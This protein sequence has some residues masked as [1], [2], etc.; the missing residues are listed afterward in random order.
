M[1]K[2]RLFFTLS[3]MSFAVSAADD[4]VLPAVNA[5]KELRIAAAEDRGLIKFAVA[6]PVKD[7]KMQNGQVQHGSWRKLGNGK[8]QWKLRFSAKNA[9]GLDIGMSDFF[10]PHSAQLTVSSDDGSLQL[11][12]YTDRDNPKDGFFWVG[13]LAADHVNMV[14]TVSEAEKDF[15][16]F[17]IDNVPRSF[18]QPWLKEAGQQQNKSG[19]CNVDVACI[20]DSSW[21]SEVDSVGQYS[22]QTVTGGYVCTGQLINNTAQDGRPYF[23]T[24]DHCGYSGD[25]GQQPLSVRQ[26]VAASISI[27]WNYQSLTC[28]PPGSAQSGTVISPS[29]FTQRQRG[30]RYVASNPVSDMALVMLNQ[31]PPSSWGVKYTGW[32]RTNT[33]PQN[34]AVSIHHPNGDAKR[35]SR[36]N[37]PLTVTSYGSTGRGDAS[38][39]RVADWNVGTTER[40]SSG[41][42]LWNA[43]RLLIGQ[44]HGGEAACGNSKPDWY[45]RFYTSWNN[46]T[47]SQSRLK[48]WLDPINSGVM[49]LQKFGGCSAPQLSLSADG[50][51]AVG[52]D[53]NFA[54]VASGGSGTYRYAWDINGDGKTDS[55]QANFTASFSHAFDGNINLTVTDSS[56]CQSKAS[57]ALIVKAPAVRLQRQ[58][59]L[60]QICGNNDA[61]IDPGERWAS[62]LTF[63]NTS[64]TVGTDAYAVFAVNRLADQTGNSDRFGNSVSSCKS[65]FIDISHTG[66]QR[67]W[68]ATTTNYAAHDEGATDPIP[69]TQP[70][71]LYGETIFSLR[72]STNG[73]LSP[74]NIGGYDYTNDCPMPAV[75]S[76]DGGSSRIAVLHDDLANSSFYHQH[77]TVCPR[78]A[79]TGSN[80]PCDV[81]MWKGADLYDT[82]D[83]VER[84]DFQAILYPSTSQWAFQYGDSINGGSSSTGI[85]NSNASDGVSYACNQAGSISSAQAVC[86][87]HKDNQPEAAEVIID[88]PTIALGNLNGSTTVD[89]EFS[90]PKDSDCGSVFS[91]N[92]QATVF[93]EGFNPG[94]NGII[95]GTIG[96]NGSCQVV[97]HCQ[98]DSSHSIDPTD[99][100]WW[101]PKRS[102]NG[103]NFFFVRDSLVYATYTGKADGSPVWYIT[104][105]TSNAAR[106]Q[107]FNDLQHISYNGGFTAGGEQTKTTVGWS[108]TIVLDTTNLIQVREINGKISAEKMQLQIFDNA[109]AVNQY[110]GWWHADSE[111]GWGENVAIQGSIRFLL[112]YLYDQSGQPYWVLGTG[113]NDNSPIDLIYVKTFCPSCPRVDPIHTPAGSSHLQLNEQGQGKIIN[114]DIAVPPEWRA[115][116]VW[117]RQNVPLV[118][119]SFGL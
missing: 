58:G 84:A 94:Q 36:E 64:S 31:V 1:N 62:R 35:I 16:R 29:T 75:P 56:G 82:G 114:I 10:L 65:H 27:I 111:S 28:R 115:G 42:G 117:Q 92:H 70:F 95:S 41:A 46:G 4:Y 109:P 119:L 17:N 19:S 106:N 61:N 60:Q 72:A 108:N 103:T 101:N 85:Q 67:Q 6:T 18:A 3:V 22:F 37:D 86:V 48:D 83:V 11:G 107:Y 40:G 26:S 54:V 30:A 78:R 25:N 87:Y 32:D 15:V 55:E 66:Q 112:H 105:G 52:Q 23:L 93:D 118:N 12:P 110:S 21:Q 63:N 104:G 38:H 68:Q 91:I 71:N 74:G 2:K 76:H 33:I 96:N 116:G 39:F 53:L 51:G 69:L 100:V 97:S 7:L 59:D 50:S 98:I 57:Q 89:F 47:N 34:G 43:D 88:T 5:D 44:L 80:L 79:E 24:A 9:K 73:Y 49:T 102:G 99:G 8:W 13:E 14:I 113:N 77:F 20:I 90:V 81:F 45:G